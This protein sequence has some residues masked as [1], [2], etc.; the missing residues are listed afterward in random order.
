MSI[1]SVSSNYIP[2]RLCSGVHQ[3]CCND[4]RTAGSGPS[5]EWARSSRW[6][7]PTARNLAGSDFETDREWHASA[8]RYGE[9]WAAWA[10]DPTWSQHIVTSRLNPLTLTL[11][12]MW[13]LMLWCLLE[14]RRRRGIPELT[15]SSAINNL[16]T[17]AL[18]GVRRCHRHN[19]DRGWDQRGMC[20]A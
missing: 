5:S 19:G 16:K 2:S 15:T 10:N 12:M 11:K 13:G 1:D 7:A 14:L 8:M 3:P 20:Q 9:G 6:S 17:T 4:Q 18:G